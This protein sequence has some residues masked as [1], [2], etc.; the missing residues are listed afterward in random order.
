MGQDVPS[1]SKKN[2]RGFARVVDPVQTI[3]LETLNRDERLV[4][5][6]SS[7]ATHALPQADNVLAELAREV[8]LRFPTRFFGQGELLSD[9]M[10]TATRLVAEGYLPLVLLGSADLA[11]SYASLSA[12]CSQRLGVIFL[13]AQGPLP[14][15][16]WRAPAT[17]DLAILRTFPDLYIG[18][19]T[20]PEELRDQL[21]ETSQAGDQ[22][23]ALYY[24][25]GRESQ[26][27]GLVQLDKLS[28][29][30]S[31]GLGRGLM[32]REGKE[33]A[34][35]ALGGATGTALAL[36]DR[37]EAQGRQ[38]AVVNVRW[39]R[40]L[41]DALLTA[42]AHHF[43]R[44]VTLEES[45]LE[46]GFGTAVLE[47]LERRELYETRLKR[48]ELEARVSLPKLTSQV[49]A[50]L[51]TL[52]RDEGLGRLSKPPNWVPQSGKL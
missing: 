12:L 45:H 34:L 5:L 3:L 15:Q 30:R 9:L 16:T 44:L 32:L 50:F 31:P 4:V 52:Q 23:I 22:P 43:P 21:A 8:A 7:L 48:L 41:D 6:A 40:P 49:T 14:G 13:L 2:Q 25:A 28:G 27:K 29:K 24:R 26:R 46:G 38:A 35:L 42:V 39:V 1:E 17:S 36:A 51:D 11:R 37:L 20:S 33:L 10:P 47:M 19:P 18:V